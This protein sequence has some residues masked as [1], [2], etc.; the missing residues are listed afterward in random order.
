M[1]APQ[2]CDHCAS[3]TKPGEAYCSGCGAVL[4]WSTPGGAVPPAAKAFLLVHLPGGIVR[5]EALAKPLVRVGR[6]R[7]CDI[8]V[9]HPRV[10]RLQALLEMRE[11]SFW[12]SDAKSSGGTFLGDRPVHAPVRLRSG[13]SCRLGR[14][15]ED[16]VTLVYHEEA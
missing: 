10:S 14:D 4:S 6:G 15:P 9:D 12:I 11:G 7:D 16:A 13:D 2:R 8:V 3:P 1:P 5:K